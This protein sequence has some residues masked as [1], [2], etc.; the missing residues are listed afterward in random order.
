MRIRRN[1]LLAATLCGGLALAVTATAHGDS[2]YLKNGR[3]IRSDDVKVEDGRV[4][5]LQLGG[6]QSIPMALV[7]RIE[8]DGWVA[9]GSPG[10]ARQPA[11]DRDGGEPAGTGTAAPAATDPAAA[12]QQLSGLMSGSTGGVD[13]AQAMQLLQALGTQDGSTGA[14]GAAALA[15]LLG[16]LGAT[17]GEGAGDAVTDLGQLSVVLPALTRLSSALFADEYD[18]AAT[19]AA[20]LDLMSALESM[21][22][23]RDEIRARAAQMGVPAEILAK[24]RAP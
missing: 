14:G 10:S 24:I 8:E 13:P 11:R 20:A 3:V 6:Y 2:I 12:L 4:V 9:P 7:E 1:H 5:F 22:V 15:P 21:G 17:G 23:S 16:M 18:A 19:E